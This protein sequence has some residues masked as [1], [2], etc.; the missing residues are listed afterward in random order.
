MKI[1]SNTSLFL[2]LLISFAKSTQAQTRT[3][4]NIGANWEF[5]MDD[6][7]AAWSKVSIPH[8]AKI[9]PL[10]IV[11]QHQGVFHYQKKI[12]VNIN[13]NQKAFL[14]FEGVMM[15]TDVFVNNQ[16]VANH[17]GGYLPFSVD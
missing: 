3:K 8:T 1:L 4:T 10:V 13:K 15:E 12:D 16:K 14:Y 5:K 2:F 7:N 17:K 6:A 9:E 11:N